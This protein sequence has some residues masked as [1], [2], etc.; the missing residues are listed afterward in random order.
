MLEELKKLNISG[1]STSSCLP[2]KDTQNKTNGEN[3]S[4]LLSDDETLLYENAHGRYSELMVSPHKMT[5]KSGQSIDSGFSSDMSSKFV[6]NPASKPKEDF[7]TGAA[8]DSSVNTDM[9]WLSGPV[10]SSV[11]GHE[12]VALPDIS[13][14]SIGSQVHYVFAQILRRFPAV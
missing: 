6:R 3:I 14:T 12:K 11:I 9:S 7:P 8:G 4:V 10:T 1:E 2:A 5:L 13:L